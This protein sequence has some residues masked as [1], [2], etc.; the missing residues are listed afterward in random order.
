MM[1]TPGNQTVV[2]MLQLVPGRLVPVGVQ[3]LQRDP[4]GGAL[5]QTF[6]DRA[7]DAVE[8]LLRILGRTLR[9]RAQR[10]VPDDCDLA[11]GH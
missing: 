7:I 8:P 1:R 10:R 3:A 5:R 9:A 2:V 4:F 6:L 11:H